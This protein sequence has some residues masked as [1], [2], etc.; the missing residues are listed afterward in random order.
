MGLAQLASLVNVTPTCLFPISNLEMKDKVKVYVKVRPPLPPESEQLAI[1]LLDTSTLLLKKGL[2]RYTMRFDAVFPPDTSQEQ[3]FQAAIPTIDR[4][5]AGHNAT[6]LAYGQT[7]A[8]KTYTLMGE[9][10]DESLQSKQGLVQQAVCR[11][12]SRLRK[13]EFQCFSSILQVY[14]EVITDLLDLSADKQLRAIEDSQGK[15]TLPDLL[16]VPVTNEAD[17]LNYIRLGLTNRKTRATAGHMKSSRSH[18]VFQLMLIRNGIESRLR[19]VDLAGSEKFEIPKNAKED[20]RKIRAKEII[21]IN[22]SLGVLGACVEALG[23]ASRTHIPYRDSKLTRL[24]RDTL[25]GDALVLVYVCVSPSVSCTVETHNSLQ[26]ADR[27]KRCLLAAPMAE[28]PMNLKAALLNEQNL[29]K[30]LERQ[31]ISREE[32]LQRLKAE[33]ELLTRKLL[34]LS[35]Q[36]KVRFLSDISPEEVGYDVHNERYNDDRIFDHISAFQD[37]AEASLE[38]SG[39]TRK[40]LN[41]EESSVIIETVQSVESNQSIE[42]DLE[43]ISPAASPDLKAGQEV[44]TAQALPPPSSASILLKHWLQFEAS[45]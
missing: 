40:R 1:D 15:L 13:E 9:E 36:K 33:N 2:A 4:F 26:F 41:F 14:N 42:E 39:N 7:G 20:E 8:G 35:G 30:D 38:S 43:A 34:R 5:I 16:Y 25:E 24:L 37:A 12:L 45:R 6:I 22:K 21:S 17:T 28:K 18:C 3:A 44:E 11:V 29:R 32:E 23:N 10:T 31:M 19:I 27:A